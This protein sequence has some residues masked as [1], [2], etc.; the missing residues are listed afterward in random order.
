V[1]L[2]PQ[3]LPSLVVGKNDLLAVHHADGRV[4]RHSLTP[5]V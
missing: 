4:V 1:A 3:A 2:R 5:G